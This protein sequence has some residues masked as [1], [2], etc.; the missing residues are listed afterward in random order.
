MSKRRK[1]RQEKKIAG[2]RR[3][4]LT[5]NSNGAVSIQVS[6]TKKQEPIQKIYMHAQVNTYN[7]QHL[8]ADL[9]KTIYTT[10]TIIGIQVIL[11]LLLKNH[12]IKLPFVVF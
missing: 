10:C 12:V 9:F 6:D 5:L 8:Y 11:F 3:Q 2:L 1:N 4:L 7:P